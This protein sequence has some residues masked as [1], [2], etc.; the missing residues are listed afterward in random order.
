MKDA[1]G[2]TKYKS[3]LLIDDSKID[4]FI[5]ERII[6]SS[7]FSEKVIV[8]TTALESLNYIKKNLDVTE[9]IPEIIFLDLNMPVMDGF[10]FLE[11]YR[12]LLKKSKPLQEKCKIIVL[13]SSIGTEDVH[14]ASSDPLVLK[15]LNKPLCESY[16]NAINF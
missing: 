14:R 10:E 6:T 15:F 2:K 7:N 8:H 13:S 3:V 5:N 9:Q 4:N 1:S 16:L 11:K 12:V